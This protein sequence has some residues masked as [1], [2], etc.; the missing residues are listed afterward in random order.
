MKKIICLIVSAMMISL[1]LFSCGNSAKPNDTEKENDTVAVMQNVN[2]DDDENEAAPDSTPA[3]EVTDNG[4]GEAD[5]QYS[6][7]E[8]Y[9][10]EH[11]QVHNRLYHSITQSFVECGLATADEITAW[12]DYAVEQEKELGTVDGC[13]WSYYNIKNFIRDMGF[14]REQVEEVFDSDLLSVHDVD[15]LFDGTDEEIEAYY[16]DLDAREKSMKRQDCLF[17][18]DV[19]IVDKY[20]TEEN[21][22]AN[23][24]TF[25]A[26]IIERVICY[27]IDR[28][29]LEGLISR[30]STKVEQA[31]LEM[32]DLNLDLIYDEDGKIKVSL[33]ELEEEAGRPLSHWELDSMLCGVDD[34]RTE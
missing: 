19:E 29:S 21:L 14:T 6:S 7:D 24:Y 26:S 27:N 34:I 30:V 10:T 31:G 1:C 18:L 23:N 25:I 4:E 28:T 15:L 13:P 22:L 2:D 11:C 33:D 12:G 17:R 32:P 9:D 8:I 20:E 3:A 16:R 5:E